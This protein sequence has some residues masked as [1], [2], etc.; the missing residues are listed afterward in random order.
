MPVMACAQG[1]SPQN[2]NVADFILQLQGHILQLITVSKGTRSVTKQD[3]IP[4]YL[5]EQQAK[6]P[7]VCQWMAAYQTVSIRRELPKHYIILLHG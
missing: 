5:L 4:F 7:Y 2:K 1:R 6:G 3:N